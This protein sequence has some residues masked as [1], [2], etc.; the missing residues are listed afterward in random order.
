[1]GVQLVQATLGASQSKGS[2]LSL[3]PS[4]LGCLV[5]LL[6]IMFLLFTG[7]NTKQLGP[8][9]AEDCQTEAVQW[10]AFAFNQLPRKVRGNVIRLLHSLKLPEC[11]G[12]H[13]TG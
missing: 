6:T 11:Q 4:R 12:K 10:W 1:M 2:A 8:E 7:K 13:Y 5:L 3:A 9:K